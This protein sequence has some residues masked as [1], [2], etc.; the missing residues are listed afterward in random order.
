MACRWFF[1]CDQSPQCKTFVWADGFANLSDKGP[2]D[3][4]RTTTPDYSNQPLIQ[5]LRASLS[6][7]GTPSLPSVPQFQHHTSSATL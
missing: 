2:P 6:R 7:L 5:V 4:G 3:P 1:A